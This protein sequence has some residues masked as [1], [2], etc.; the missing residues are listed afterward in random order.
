M[1]DLHGFVLRC[2]IGFSSIRANR[3]VQASEDVRV[4]SDRRDAVKR[5]DW[6]NRRPGA[7]LYWS[8]EPTK[9]G[10][11]GRPR[12]FIRVPAD[13]CPENPLMVLRCI[14]ELVPDGGPILET[15][16][17]AMMPAVDV[18]LREELAASDRLFSGLSLYQTEV[19]A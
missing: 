3:I 12:R 4:W 11:I 7:L 18:I 17:R 5:A 1:S 9:E 13:V 16:L 15:D 2:E 19:A 6:L 8:V 14:R 10:S